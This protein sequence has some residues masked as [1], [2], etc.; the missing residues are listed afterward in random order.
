VSTIHSFLWKLIKPFQKD[1]KSWVVCYLS[2]KAL[3]L[4]EK[5][6]RARSKDYRPDIEKAK[7]RLE[8][9]KTIN[10][11]TYNPNGEN[12]G[13]NSLD[14]SQVISMGTEFICENTTLQKVLVSKYPILLID[15][16]QDTKK[17]LVDA[18]LKIESLYAGSFVIGMFGD[19]M[20][21]IYADGKDNSNT[22][23]LRLFYVTCTR[24]IESLVLIAYTSDTE[25][26]KQTA[27]KNRWFDESEI[28]VVR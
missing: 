14:H 5:A 28:E 13:Q 24:A 18:L 25:I 27:L 21:R 7:N 1:I 22:R 17:E 9:A 8:R 19:M 23:T 6:S 4:E 15:E 16:S 20:Q 26:V 12:I 10:K 3:E 2:A 11:F